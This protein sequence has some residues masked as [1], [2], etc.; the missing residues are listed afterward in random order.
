MSAQLDATLRQFGLSTAQVGSALAAL[1]IG[2][3]ASASIAS[4]CTPGGGSSIDS[5]EGAAQGGSAQFGSSNRGNRNGSSVKTST[6]RPSADANP[7]PEA[8][9]AADK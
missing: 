7:S 5:I 8:E 6:A 2:I 4:A 1:V 3:T 9:P